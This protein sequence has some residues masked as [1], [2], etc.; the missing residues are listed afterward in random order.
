MAR[1]L[2]DIA[3]DSGG[4]CVIT[5]TLNTRHVDLVL[6]DN[7]GNC[8]LCGGSAQYQ[9][10]EGRSS[11]VRSGGPLSSP[12]GPPLSE[13]ELAARREIAAA[14]AEER[15]KKFSQGGGGERLK[16]KAK[17]LEEAERK[18]RELGGSNTLKWNV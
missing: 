9:P 3:S 15:S 8:N 4:R 7:M 17:A 6:I 18:N 5:W 2:V 16:A 12:S 11:F 14:A 13:E 1:E 10:H